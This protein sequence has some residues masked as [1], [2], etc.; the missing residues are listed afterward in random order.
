[1]YSGFLQLA[2]HIV[3]VLYLHIVL[4]LACRGMVCLRNRKYAP[5]FAVREDRRNINILRCLAYGEAV[6]L[7]QASALVLVTSQHS[8]ACD[9]DSM[10]SHFVA[11]QGQDC[12][13]VP[14]GTQQV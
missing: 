2:V 7:L 4:H 10:A 14:H 13:D 9:R 12:S 3:V 8:P 1:M 11:V 5:C 6:L